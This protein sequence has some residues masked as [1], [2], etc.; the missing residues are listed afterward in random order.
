MASETVDGM[1][2]L[3]VYDAMTRA[4]K[5]GREDN[6]PTLLEMR[7]YRFMGHS[8]S[9]PIHGHYRTKQ[10]IEEQRARDP[11]TLFRE[12]LVSEGMLSED[13][14]AAMD[15]EIKAEVDDAI[16]FAD[17]SPDPDPAEICAD[18]YLY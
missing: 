1:D 11:I 4:V 8:M 16:Q 15:Q 14:Y 10:E 18:V 5:R 13:A 7:T 12:Q 17:E 3:A 9:D 2:V 6:L